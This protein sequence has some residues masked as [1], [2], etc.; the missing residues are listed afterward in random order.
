MRLQH[1]FSLIEILVTLIILKI[2][3][4]GVLTAQTTSLRQLQDAIQRTQAVALSASLVNHFQSNSQLLRH[5]Q[6]PITLQTELPSDVVCNA[7]S[8]C[9]PSLAGQHLLVGWFQQLRGAGFSPL[10]APLFC[11]QP[12]D[13]G[14]KL[15]VSWQQLSVAEFGQAQCAAG[16]GRSGFAIS[17][18]GG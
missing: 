16:N 9:E 3:L 4:L 7:M 17:S 15:Q 13:S 11:T 14:L 10:R 12:E 1:G 2:G 6:G 5:L 18:H 8:P